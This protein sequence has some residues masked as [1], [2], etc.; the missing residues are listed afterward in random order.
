MSR[1]TILLGGAVVRTDR[2]LRQVAGTRVIAADGG[3]THAKPLGL[4]PELW[5]GDFDSSSGGL[6]DRHRAVPRRIHPPDKDKT[7]G[8]LAVEEALV[9]GAHAIVMAGALG[10]QIDHALGHAVL[11]IGLA[12]RG[13]CVLLSSGSEEAH[14]LIAGEHDLDL[15]PGSRLSIVGLAEMTGLHLEGTRWPLHD[16]H[17]RLG[18]TLTLSNVA[19]GTVRVRLAS[20][21]GLAIAY[22]RRGAA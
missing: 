7:D 19:E 11:A 1:F 4:E 10:G 16:T 5:V 18:S 8:E 15:P 9:R 21:Y 12:Q 14:P 13:I 6:Q 3:M 17:V 2:L 20:G 22:P